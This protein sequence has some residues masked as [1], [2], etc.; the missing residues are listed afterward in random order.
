MSVKYV[1]LHEQVY[2]GI[3]NIRKIYISGWKNL[4]IGYKISRKGFEKSLA[5]KEILLQ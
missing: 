3:D 2:L 4:L 5:A 1:C